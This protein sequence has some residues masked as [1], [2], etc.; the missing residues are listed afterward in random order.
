MN[1][2]EGTA[3]MNKPIPREELDAACKRLCRRCAAAIIGAMA[4]TN[5][6]ID[7]IASRLGKQPQ[8][9][10]RTLNRLIDGLPVKLD[11]I[12]D[13]TSAMGCELKLTMTTE[14]N[15]AAPTDDETPD[16]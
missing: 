8:T 3:D 1:Y 16:A 14:Q 13:I 7:V 5:T 4:Y 11:A 12:S 9:I 2:F 6:D 15:S 10:R